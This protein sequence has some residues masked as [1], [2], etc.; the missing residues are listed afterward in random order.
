MFDK[1]I[2]KIDVDINIMNNI[3]EDFAKMN[4]KTRNSKEVR[5]ILKL[6]ETMKAGY[7][8]EYYE[9]IDSY[10]DQWKEEYRS[11]IR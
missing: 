4:E 3:M 5:R 10:I 8:E 2:K 1:G 7:V 6:E 9:K 11:E